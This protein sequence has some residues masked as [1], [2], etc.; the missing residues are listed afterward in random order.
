MLIPKEMISP[1]CIQ[2]T[3][4]PSE[5]EVVLKQLKVEKH[6]WKKMVKTLREDAQ[7][8]KFENDSKYANLRKIERE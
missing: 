7:N 1:I 3:D 8:L 4:L 6:T 2:L 5:Q